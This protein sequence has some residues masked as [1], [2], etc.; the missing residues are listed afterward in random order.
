MKIR[1]IF[2]QMGSSLVSFIPKHL[3]P[4]IS[5]PGIDRVV[6]TLVLTTSLSCLQEPV[7]E[8]I[9]EL[10]TK[11]VLTFTPTAGGP[12]VVVT[13]SDPDGEGFQDISPDGPIILL[14]NSTYNLSVTLINELTDPTSPGYDITD[15]VRNEGTEHIFF[16]AW[17]NNLF[18]APSGNGNVDNR[19]DELIY[20]DVDTAGLPIGLATNWTTVSA[21]GTGTFRI[22]LKHQPGIKTSTSGSKDGETDLDITFNVEVL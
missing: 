22:M 4:K 13:A 1:I 19:N 8:D 15:E 17:I 5:F 10:I 12:A 11:A 9:P 6:L 3:S 16:F 7:K 20:M 14:Q 2:K 21:I 18:F